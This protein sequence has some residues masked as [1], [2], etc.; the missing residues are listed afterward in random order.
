MMDNE[1]VKEGSMSKDPLERRS[2]RRS[3]GRQYGYDYDPLRNQRGSAASK[4]DT[5]LL[6]RPDPRRTR[7]FLRQSIIA[8]KRSNSEDAAPVI[9]REQDI[10]IPHTP[11][12]V[13]PT[14]P[15]TTRR[16]RRTMQDL[17]YVEL[18]E[19]KPTRRFRYHPPNNPKVTRR[20]HPTMQDDLYDQQEEQDLIA[21][22]GARIPSR[23]SRLSAPRSPVT[24]NLSYEDKEM[25]EEWRNL[26]DEE[27]EYD[28]DRIYEENEEL[29]PGLHVVERRKTSRRGLLIGVGIGIGT[30]VLALGGI[31]AASELAP[32]SAPLNGGASDAVQEAF[33]RGVAQGSDSAR[34]ELIS[35]LGTLEGFTL[36]GAIDAA[37]LTRIAYDTFI[38]PIVQFGSQLTTN[39]LSAMLS[40]LKTA[41][42]WLAGIY[43]DNATLAAV[44]HVLESWVDQAS[45]LP[46]QLDAITQTDL[47]GA[48]AYLI[49]LQRKITDEESQLNSA[50]ATPAVSAGKAASLS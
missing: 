23:S 47:D 50:Q 46:K 19:K 38:S 25:Y 9:H 26:E 6:Q 49:A 45:K 17:A 42:G 13:S 36:Q 28:L 21:Q 10:I 35:A 33:N 11:M 20:I 41:R 37:K 43:Q 14:H 34:R 12:S 30:G 15:R 22:S 32:K 24:R 44:Q 31:V 18:N 16:I 3:P 39:F 27:P 4:P 8:S 48:Q 5:I 29:P 2:Y 40:A 7:Q 1:Q